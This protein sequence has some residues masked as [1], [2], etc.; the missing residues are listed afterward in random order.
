M[1]IPLKSAFQLLTA[2]EYNQVVQGVNDGTAVQSIGS[3]SASSAIGTSPTAI[4]T[5]TNCVMKSGYAYTVENIGGAFGSTANEADFSLWK[6]STAGAQ[7]G[8]F[9]RTP[10]PGAP[11][12]NCYGKIY[13]RRTGVDL[14]F[15]MVLAV[16]AS[17]GTVSHD[18]ASIRPRA[19]VVRPCGAASDY[20]YAYDVP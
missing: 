20:P 6:T 10:T 16:A 14:T 12:R 2:T 5:L 3:F 4:L 9:Y 1:V 8:A 19:L 15:D 17:T 18:A 7:I 11:Q 13:L